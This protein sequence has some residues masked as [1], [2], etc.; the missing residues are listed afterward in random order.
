MG[1]SPESPRRDPA[2]AEAAAERLLAMHRLQ[3]AADSHGVAHDRIVSRLIIVAIAAL[4]G[5]SCGAVMGALRGH[6]V[7]GALLVGLV[8]A[9]I[10][11]ITSRPR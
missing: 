9:M 1:E 11:L 5:A 3:Q 8:G 6:G 10:A 4:V 7:A 2:E